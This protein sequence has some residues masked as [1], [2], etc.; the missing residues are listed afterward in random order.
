MNTKPKKKT[1]ILSRVIKVS[2]SVIF[3]I[4]L[5]FFIVIQLYKNDLR[6]Y[7]VQYFE[8]KAKL[9]LNSND[10]ALDFWEYFPDLAL[11]ITSDSA[12]H[13][14]NSHG[15]DLLTAQ[16]IELLFNVPDLIRNKFN[17]KHI[18]LENGNAWFSNIKNYF[19]EIN[20]T[21]QK[22]GSNDINMEINSAFLSDITLFIDQ[23]KN[24]QIEII[25]SKLKADWTKE[26][27]YL[28]ISLLCN[29]FLNNDN[30]RGYQLRKVSSDLELLFNESEKYFEII[31]GKLD[32][33]NSINLN[34][35][36]SIFTN[37]DC[38]INAILYK[39]NIPELLNLIPQPYKS[40][41][42]RKIVRGDIEGKIVLNYDF[43]KNQLPSVESIFSVSDASILIETPITE[44]NNIN[45][46]GHFKYLRND[47]TARLLL[48]KITATYKDQKIKG[49]LHISNF[50][51]PLIEANINGIIDVREFTKVIFDDSL[52]IINGIVD[53][54]ISYRRQRTGWGPFQPQDLVYSHTS[55][56]L[57]KIKTKLRS[58]K[59]TITIEDGTIC[60]NN[61]D[62]QA[63]NIKIRYN[64]T[65]LDIDMSSEDFFS[66]LLFGKK[67]L[68][69]N[70]SSRSPFI[71]VN[72]II[73]PVNHFSSGITQ[74][75]NTEVTPVMNLK[76]MI[77]SVK[78]YQLKAGN[79]C[80]MA[81][82]K[83]GLITV[84]G[85]KM[86]AFGGKLNGRCDLS[87]NDQ[88]YDFILFS[89]VSKVDIKKV[90]MGFDNFGQD[91]I[92]WQNLD[93]IADMNVDLSMQTD[94]SFRVIPSSVLSD[95]D[96]EIQNGI[97][98]N[99]RP[100]VETLKSLKKDSVDHIRFSRLTNQIRI[101]D[102][103]VII[104]QMEFESNI[105]N[106]SG[107]GYHHFDGHFDYHIRVL[108][109]EFWSGKRNELNENVSKYGYLVDDEY[110]KTSMFFHLFG[111]ND[112]VKF[113]YDK[114]AVLEKIA[115]DFKR[116]SHKMK[117]EFAE[118]FKWLKRDSAKKSQHKQMQKKIEKQEEGKFIIKW[119]QKDPD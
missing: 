88:F 60:F 43:T 53:A 54:D 64:K 32:Y 48:N 40:D 69:I 21:N 30:L 3:L 5:S 70:L 8:E 46:E 104:P 58:G 42:E 94:H 36:N 49:S 78:Y 107:F 33:D 7:A 9:T 45:L 56:Q 1:R 74:K 67:P 39:S 27:K 63:N 99:F 31:N 24:Y 44:L 72:E 80:G 66:A 71:D 84:R 100:L 22:T 83:K 106:F 82:F 61:N 37:Q 95:V 101:E 57:D 103:K 28:N 2:I 118:E 47:K 75:N 108:M 26:K 81:E 62:I 92:S 23:D 116:E 35:K 12:F 52:F 10:I 51:K 97:L 4:L 17:A 34:L 90:F 50:K 38:K 119:G 93:G 16:K 73:P 68:I 109:T 110:G 55:A 77:D 87:L 6:E 59:E 96:I 112:E 113:K 86:N 65:R 91:N 76:I 15:L 29:L 89:S 115:D 20:T 11:S 105:Y 114:K 41:I 18:V 102:K 85:I 111:K 19:N 117:I 25:H 13:F 14:V 79:I 98:K